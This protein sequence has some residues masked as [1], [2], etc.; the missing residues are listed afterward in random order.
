[1]KI[2]KVTAMWCMSCLVM[3]K[4]YKKAFAGFENLELIEYDFDDDAEVLKDLN[5]GEVLPLLIVYHNNEEV[6]RI[7]GEKSFKQIKEIL[8]NI[9]NA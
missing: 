1:M 2:I 4:V 5:V 7:A 9:Y 8:D 3:Q 6:K